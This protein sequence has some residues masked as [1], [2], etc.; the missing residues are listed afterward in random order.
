M[1]RL[2]PSDARAIESARDDERHAQ[3]EYESAAKAEREA[4]R[5]FDR[6][7]SDVTRAGRGVIIKTSEAAT[8]GRRGFLTDLTSP[9][10]VDPAQEAA[11]AT[12][13]E[14]LSLEDQLAAAEQALIEAR[15]RRERAK[16]TLKVR[17]R[18]RRVL[19]ALADPAAAA[20]RAAHDEVL[21]A[22]E[23]VSRADAAE[24]DADKAVEDAMDSRDNG[25]SISSV[26][27]LELKDA[28]A[29]AER[30][31][32]RARTVLDE[33]SAAYATAVADFVP[34]AAVDH[35]SQVS[36]TR[37]AVEAQA[38]MSL[39]HALETVTSALS[40]VDE[41]GQRLKALAKDAGIESPDV[42]GVPTPKS[43]LTQAFGR[44]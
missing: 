21:S 29:D 13:A 5:E 10:V 42:A 20:V 19:E 43:L 9:I 12:A 32:R 44:L 27:L 37:K 1:T 22:R 24:A 17:I 41:Q 4:Q 3:A 31:T 35:R 26:D 11:K 16:V 39:E 34:S 6:L 40:V 28:L 30:A 8:P 2:S 38:Q 36:Q 25:G 14:F 7:S 18:S 23:A 15:D 33:A